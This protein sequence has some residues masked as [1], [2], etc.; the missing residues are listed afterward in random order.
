MRGT[1]GELL[2]SFN[3]LVYWCNQANNKKEEDKDVNV[4]YVILHFLTKL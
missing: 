1:G 2:V 4:L 3:N